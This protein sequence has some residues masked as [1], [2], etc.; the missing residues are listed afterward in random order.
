MDSKGRTLLD[1]ALMGVDDWKAWNYPRPRDVI[2]YHLPVPKMV[3][4]LLQNGAHPDNMSDLLL[5]LNRKT[6]EQYRDAPRTWTKVIILIIRA[7]LYFDTEHTTEL[8][9]VQ[10]LSRG[11][12]RTE[13]V[14]GLQRGHDCPES[15]SSSSSNSYT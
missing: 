2:D 12:G 1:L 10:S 5:Y 4:T 6:A 14:D 3:E 8:E 9:E 15:S 7:S 13:T 11:V